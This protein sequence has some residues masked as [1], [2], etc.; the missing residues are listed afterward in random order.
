M[1]NERLKILFVDF[2]GVVT[3]QT[4]VP[5]SYITHEADEYGA[6]PSCLSRLKD[7]CDSTGSKIVISSNWRRFDDDGPCSFWVYRKCMRT[8]CNPLPKFKV[9]LKDY[10]IG[11]LPKDRHINKAEALVLW[12]EE[13]NLAKDDLDYV[14]FDDDLSEGFATMTDYDIN[15]HFVQTS[16]VTGL[17]EDDVRR[18]KA[19]LNCI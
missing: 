16:N 5:G 18:A 19:I 13:N 7:L 14:I 10:I 1:T 8:V 4:E 12:F 15:K 9:Q 3:S 2:D 17:T 11:M 6:S